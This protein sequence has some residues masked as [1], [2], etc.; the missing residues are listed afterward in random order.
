QVLANDTDVDSSSLTTALVAGALHGSV[1]H[2]PDGTFTYTPDAN[3]YGGDSFTY[4]LNDGDK[5]SNVV[6]VSITVTPVN[7][8][9]VAQDAHLDA[10]EDHDA[11]IRLVNYASDI[12]NSLLTASIVSGPAHGTLTYDAAS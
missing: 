7:D 6:T 4:K 11:F 8:A 5:D 10:I 1:V 12:E 3:Y 2:N 9:P